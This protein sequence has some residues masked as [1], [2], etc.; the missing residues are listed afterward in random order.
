MS[1]ADVLGL[2]STIAALLATTYAAGRWAA[3]V[4]HRTIGSRRVVR[5]QLDGIA[6]GVTLAYLEERLGRP[7]FRRSYFDLV[8]LSWRLPHAWFCGLVGDDSLLSFAIT[9][10]DPKFGYDCRHLTFGHLPV[11]LGRDTLAAGPEPAKTTVSVGARRAYVTDEHYFGN[12]GAYQQYL[13]AYNDQGVGRLVADMASTDAASLPT[14]P[15]PAETARVR[16]GTTANT[17]VVGAAHDDRTWR[18]WGFPGVDGDFVRTL[19][20]TD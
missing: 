14:A 18:L 1:L 12:P 7:A 8:E 2:A 5:R 15:D 9:V 16:A 4:W 6:C 13:L 11:T 20:A 19:R 10:T 3:G 17:L